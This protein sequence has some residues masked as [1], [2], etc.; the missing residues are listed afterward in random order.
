MAIG[1]ALAG[2]QGDSRAVVFPY[3]AARHDLDAVR[4]Y[5]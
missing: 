3:I 1:H 2:A 4:A 5:L